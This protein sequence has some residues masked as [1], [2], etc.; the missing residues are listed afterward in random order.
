MKEKLIRCVLA[1]IVIF[2]ASCSKE[3]VLGELDIIKRTGD[4]NPQKALAMLDSLEYE[5]RESSDYTKAKSDLLR[6]RLSDKSYIMP[7]S[8]I[9]IRKLIKYFEKEGAAADKQEVYFYAGSVYRDLQDT[10]RSLEY[11]LTWRN[12]PKN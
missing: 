7:T 2:L 6:I 5:I 12:L 3:D 8:D 4:Q 11:F 10:P 1:F 9:P